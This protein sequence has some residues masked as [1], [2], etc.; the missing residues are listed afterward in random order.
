M[1]NVESL[2]S[3]KEISISNFLT[4]L[5]DSI[6]E[7]ARKNLDSESSSNTA[8]QDSDQVADL[9]VKR[10]IEQ[11]ELSVQDLPMVFQHKWLPILKQHVIKQH[12][13]GAAK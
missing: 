10:L 12:H 7:A 13:L 1:A 2:L 5:A 4:S 8:Y 6:D 3:A 11:I 9:A